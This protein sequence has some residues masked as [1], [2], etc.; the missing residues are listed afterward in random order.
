MYFAAAE[1]VKMS[2]FT[3]NCL[4]YHNRVGALLGPEH[5]AQWGKNISKLLNVHASEY[6]TVLD[7]S[8][9]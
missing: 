6:Q 9:K 3:F 2:V 5:R 4:S 8:V 1:T 7:I